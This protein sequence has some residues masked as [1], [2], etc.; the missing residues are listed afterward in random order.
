MHN[1]FKIYIFIFFRRHF[2]L[3][4]VDATVAQ[5][6]GTSEERRARY[7]FDLRRWYVKPKMSRDRA[8]ELV[9]FPTF[10][11]SNVKFNSILE[12]YSYHFYQAMCLTS[13]FIGN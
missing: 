1:P 4:F 13:M 11:I 12:F 2:R 7:D 5:P 8:T 3:L 10:Q 6:A 9:F